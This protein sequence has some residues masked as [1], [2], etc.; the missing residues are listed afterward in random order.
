MPVR[1]RRLR[2][3]QIRGS[4]FGLREVNFEQ[5]KVSTDTG[6]YSTASW[7]EA[8]YYAYFG[9]GRGAAAPLPTSGTCS[10]YRL[11]MSNETFVT[12]PA[13]QLGRAYFGMSGLTG[14]FYGYFAGAAN[15][16]V[17]T[18][19]RI[20]YLTETVTTP[21]TVCPNRAFA[22]VAQ[23]SNA[24]FI[25]G[26]STNV[27]GT[28][29]L[30]LVN[31]F[32]PVVDA[33]FATPATIGP[34]VS[35][36]GKNQGGGCSSSS[37]GYFIGGQFANS[38]P[39]ASPI[40]PT[41]TVYMI[42]LKTG[43]SISAV[44]NPVFTTPATVGATVAQSNTFGYISNSNSVTK[45]NFYD[46]TRSSSGSLPIS[47]SGR[48]NASNNIFGYFVGGGPT[49]TSIMD[50]L[51]FATDTA[52][53]AGSFVGG[54]MDYIG[55]F[56]VG[57]RRVKIGW[58]PQLS[59]GFGYNYGGFSPAVNSTIDRLSF[60]NDTNVFIA[61]R[62]PGTSTTRNQGVAS[63]PPASY[64]YIAGG[65]PPISCSIV[66]HDFSDDSVVTRPST[67]PAARFGLFGVASSTNAYFGGGYFTPV[68]TF[69]C[70]IYRMSFST[71]T[72]TLPGSNLP[73][74]L[75]ESGS[76]QSPT[77]GFICGGQIPGG[78]SCTIHKITFSTD[79]ISLPG[80]NISIASAKIAGV[81]SNT[82]GYLAG[83]QKIGQASPFISVT[84]NTIHRIDFSTET[85]STT[86]QALPR[87]YGFRGAGGCSAA[88]NGYFTAGVTNPPGGSAY[89]SNIIKMSFATETNFDMPIKTTR[90]RYTHGS[91]STIK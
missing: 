20:D 23:D 86:P 57:G 83:G 7:S 41:F 62:L 5:S 21:T 50:R 84:Y 28:G 89:I 54:A 17:T 2:T 32:D 90:N 9:G 75:L 59:L 67:L 78:F 37:Y 70:T 49:V 33:M 31:K 55:S 19:K 27:P 13:N 76:F 1:K 81:E 6:A 58:Q 74:G 8:D 42:D 39:F 22:Q 36:G 65:T 80:K 53:S 4:V 46:D 72:V 91:G 51:N 60:T 14:N 3:T 48:A 85:V 35:P 63:Y 77:L 68:A 47:R 64:I 10:V 34:G 61:F 44:G 26:G 16:V 38:A 25:A 43:T 30:S 88:D 69:S 66:R 73:T 24:A 45:L 29:S 82:Y 56:S 12:P 52:S 40:S 15:P 11:D 79:T 18:V 71:E 87:T